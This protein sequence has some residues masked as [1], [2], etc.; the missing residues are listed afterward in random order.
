MGYQRFNVERFARQFYRFR[1]M[2]EYD[3]EAGVRWLGRPKDKDQAFL[4]LEQVSMFDEDV[5]QEIYEEQQEEEKDATAELEAAPAESTSGQVQAT[6]AEV[7]EDLNDKALP[8]GED[9][10]PKDPDDDQ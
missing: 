3:P 9:T 10:E 4:V 1:E 2:F 6:D 5:Y 7:N 8:G